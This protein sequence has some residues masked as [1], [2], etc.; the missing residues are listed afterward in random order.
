MKKKLRIAIVALVVIGL[1]FAYRQF[2]ANSRQAPNV[3]R[4]SGN[5]EVTDAEVSF[6]IAGRVQERPAAEGQVIRAG[7]LVARLDST[8]LA[9]EVALR[10]AEVQ[11]AAAALAELEAGSRPEDITQAEA[12]ARRAK[13]RLQELEAGS[14][15]EELAVADAAVQRARADRQRLQADHE[16]Y[17]GLYRKA[18]ISA[19]QYD[20]ARTAYAIAAARQR[21][22]EE[23]WK[24]VK[25]GPRKEQY[26]AGARRLAAGP[27]AIPPGQERSAQRD[28]RAGPGS[29]GAGA[30]GAGGG[31]NPARLCHA[32]FSPGRHGALRERRG[33]RVRGRRHT[34]G[35][36]RRPRYPWLRA[37]INESDL[38][39][40]K[41]GQRVQVTTDT[42]PGKVYQGRVSFIASQAEFTPKNVQTEKE[43]VK[44]VYRVKID[45]QNPNM[46]LKPGMPAD[47]DILLSGGQGGK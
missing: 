19:Q 29:P 5:I 18:L 41:A 35:H 25:E 28:Y 42:Y 15:A 2:R 30:A 45:L 33:G 27:G 3:V 31:R 6:K 8:E 10:K 39:R 34:G 22:A 32:G 24:L 21:E 36:G 16:R 7:Q 20:A 17:T 14:R 46:E 1:G 23:Q 43:R 47:A 44:L 26:P 11:A 12:N 4:V 38:G 13:A 40:V 37:Y 9:Q